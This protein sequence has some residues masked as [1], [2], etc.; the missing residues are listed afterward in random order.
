MSWVTTRSPGAMRRTI[1]ASATSNPPATWMLRMKREGGVRIHWLATSVTATAS[2]SA[3]RNRIS[4][5]TAGQA[6]ASTQ[7][8]AGGTAVASAGS[9]AGSEYIFDRA[10]EALRQGVENVL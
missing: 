10:T 9:E 5:I 2:R 8:A 3:A 4:L 1:S 6:S 7:M